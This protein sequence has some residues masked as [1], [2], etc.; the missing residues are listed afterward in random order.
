MDNI[1]RLHQSVE[2]AQ[3]ASHVGPAQSHFCL[4]PIPNQQIH[5]PNLILHTLPSIIINTNNQS[6]AK[7]LTGGRAL[8]SK[9]NQHQ[10]PV[11]GASRWQASCSLSP[12]GWNGDLRRYACTQQDGRCTHSPSNLYGIE[13]YPFHVH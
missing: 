11:E 4:F 2:K 6:P 8:E 3:H 9:E 7:E 5:H 1:I 10:R 12:E 13:S